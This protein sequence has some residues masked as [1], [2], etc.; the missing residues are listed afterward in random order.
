MLRGHR[1]GRS[2]G[3]TAAPRL[4]TL[5]IAGSHDG[6]SPPDLVAATAA[7]IPDAQVHVINRTGHLPYIED[8]AAFADVLTPLL[9][10]HAYV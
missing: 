8:P 2:D 7:L 6:S 5:A 1:S 9:Q 4:P 10:E 3:N